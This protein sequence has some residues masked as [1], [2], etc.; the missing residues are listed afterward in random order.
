VLF[1]VNVV[2]IGLLD[3]FIKKHNQAGVPLT[4]WL[5]VTQQALW[6]HLVDVRQNY[7]G[8]DGNVKGSYTVFNIKGNSY[9]YDHWN[10]TT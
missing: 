5:K 3:A 1:K 10:K 7:P 4:A 8:T 9:R 6:K 2:N